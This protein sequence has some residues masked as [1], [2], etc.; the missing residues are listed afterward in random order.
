[1]PTITCPE[2]GGK[3][4]FPEDSPPRRVKCPACGKV[5]LSSDGL[6]EPPPPPKKS[7]RRPDDDRDSADDRPSRRRRDDDD[8]RDGRRSSRRR[9]E[10]DDFD[11]DRDDRRPRRRDRDDDDRDDR[12][13]RK[14]DRAKADPN[15]VEGQFNRAGLACFLLMIAGW[16]I[17]AG[18][19]LVAFRVFLA[20]C[21][22]TDNT[23][24]F[25]ILGGILGVCGW[26]TGIVGL[27]FVVS[28]P[29]DR[30][31]IG[32]GV[33]AAGCGLFHLMLIFVIP[34][35]VYG[36]LGATVGAG[37]SGIVWDNFVTQSRAIPTWLFDVI[38]GNNI[39]RYGSLP[40][41]PL[42]ANL[43]EVGRFVLFLLF[44]RSVMLCAGDTKTARLCMKTVIGYTIG[45]GALIVL[46]A[47]LGVIYHLATPGGV[48]ADRAGKQANELML[49]LFKLVQC[50]AIAGLFAWLSLITMK[51]KGRIDYR[52]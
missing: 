25:E 22:F 30:G 4:K 20:M 41:L 33:A 40:A 17:V 38:A 11:D 27:G 8:D 9:D 24:V 39:R 46:A 34:S 32:L 29:R 28:G 7:S 51:V 16:L 15:A 26:L 49:H 2:C 45:A 48:Q 13:V 47:V 36:E 18:L 31:A 23:E 42:L 6:D 12:P 52:A 1:M 5:F 3:S 10:D 35:T 50:L 14:R 43:A 44:L 37:R 19:G 21:G